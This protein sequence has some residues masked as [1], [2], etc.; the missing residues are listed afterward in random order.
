ME[1]QLDD[2]NVWFEY[3]YDTMDVLEL[4]SDMNTND[5]IYRCQEM[6][7]EMVWACK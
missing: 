1:K 5:D 6:S 2:K 3:E 4:E 7:F